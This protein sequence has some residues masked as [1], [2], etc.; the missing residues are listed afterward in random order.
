MLTLQ[1]EAEAQGG[2]LIDPK[3]HSHLVA[4]TEFWPTV[5]CVITQPGFFQ[6]FNT[7]PFNTIKVRF[8]K[9]YSNEMLTEVSQ[10]VK[11]GLFFGSKEIY[12]LKK[13]NM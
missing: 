2:E 7:V 6:P 8:T 1:I 9:H 12:I 11:S 5:A 3:S 13:S 4:G 10:L